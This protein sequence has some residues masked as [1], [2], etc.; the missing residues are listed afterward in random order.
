M[1]FFMFLFMRQFLGDKN[2]LVIVFVNGDAVLA[3]LIDLQRLLVLEDEQFAHIGFTSA[4]GDHFQ[5]HDIKKWTFCSPACCNQFLRSPN[6]S[7]Q[8]AAKCHKPLPQS[9]G[10]DFSNVVRHFHFHPK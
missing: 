6:T 1:G 10:A 4:T 3:L 7:G 9:P 2:G 5:N 8:S